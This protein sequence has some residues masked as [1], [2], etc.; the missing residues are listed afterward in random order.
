[1]ITFVAVVKRKEGLGFDDFRKLWCEEHPELVLAM[2]GVRGYQQQL[3]HDGARRDWPIDGV[4]ELSFDDPAAMKAAF[5][6][7]EGQAA[8]DHQELFAGDVTWFLAEPRG[9]GARA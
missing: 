7:P 5:A 9:Y 1:M 6:S 8:T 4:A 2:P 3:A